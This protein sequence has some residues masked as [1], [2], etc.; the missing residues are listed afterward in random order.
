MQ[1]QV[2]NQ[3]R[4]GREPKWYFEIYRGSQ[5]GLAECGEVFSFAEIKEKLR[6]SRLSAANFFRV[7]GPSSATPDELEE[8][9]KLGAYPTF[10]A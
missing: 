1:R 2:L 6:I 3:P 4:T 5:P 9:R 7:I 10:P 8:L